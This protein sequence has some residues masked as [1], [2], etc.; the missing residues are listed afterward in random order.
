[1]PKL[2]F[3]EARMNLLKPLRRHLLPQELFPTLVPDPVKNATSQRRSHRAHYCIEKKSRR[4]LVH[5]SG[6]D[7]VHGKAHSCRVHGRNEQNAPRTHGSQNFPEEGSVLRK[8]G[9]YRF[10]KEILT[11]DN[12]QPCC[13]LS[14]A[15]MIRHHANTVYLGRFLTADLSRLCSTI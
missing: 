13:S 11:G 12:R 7:Q 15:Y 5:I 6:N 14:A 10:Q 1:R 4:L 2:M 9:F 3:I 8:N